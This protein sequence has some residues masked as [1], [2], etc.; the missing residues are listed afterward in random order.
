M[1]GQSGED[2]ITGFI[3]R[4]N[5]IANPLASQGVAAADR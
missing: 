4:R 2:F 5:I 3:I 1:E